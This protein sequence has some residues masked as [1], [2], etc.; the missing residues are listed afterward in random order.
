MLN[1]RTTETLRLLFLA[2]FAV[3]ISTATAFAAPAG[4]TPI[5]RAQIRV[6]TA[7][8]DEAGSDDYVKVGLNANNTTWIE[9]DQDD[10]ARNDDQTYDLQLLNLTQLSDINFLR[11]EK[12]GDDGW[13]LKQIYLIINGKTIYSVDFGAGRWLDNSSGDSRIYN[14]DGTFM[15]AS[16]TWANYWSPYKPSV[17]SLQD[18]RLRIEA[19]VGDFVA[20][21]HATN[22]F[23][24]LMHREGDYGTELYTYNSN[25]WRV[26]LDLESDDTFWNVDIDVDFDL[27]VQCVSGRPTFSVANVSASSTPDRYATDGAR[28]YAT[29]Y[30][31]F[32]LNQMF[33]NYKAYQNNCYYMNV[34]LSPN[35]DLNIKEQNIPVNARGLESS[36][37]INLQINPQIEVV[38]DEINSFTATVTNESAENTEAEISFDLTS[39]VTPLDAIVEAKEGKKIRRIT[40]KDI[41]RKSDGSSRV[42]FRDSLR[43]GKHTEYAVRLM[44]QPRENQTERIVTR[45]LPVD[46]TFAAQTAPLEAATDLIAG[47]GKVRL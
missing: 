8:T 46:E 21:Q 3:F 15:R 14:V 40:A 32:Y 4:T 36:S 33:K 35:G 2:L 29:N 30:I 1:L 26:D 10:F 41:I 13:R 42:V 12:T 9:S 39:G 6:V 20:G 18:M 37:P 27:K 28:Y 45:I 47:S 25:T 17:I 16:S 11:I 7:N 43:A 24:M 23:Q 34:V 31:H 44:Y 19:I 22:G 5:Y 38:P